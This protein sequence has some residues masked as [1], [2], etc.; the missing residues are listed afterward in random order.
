ML[1]IALFLTLGA[2]RA[3]LH[4]DLPQQSD[5]V[6]S[7]T[8]DVRLRPET[9]SVDGTMELVWRNTSNMAV[10][11]L[12]FHLYLNAF[13]DKDSTFM[14]ESGGGGRR[15][16]RWDKDHPGKVTVR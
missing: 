1:T 6:V 13:S 12:Y 14:R 2:E 3:G 11:K 8:M 7:Y 16:S 15:G 4:A 9:Q 5:R 10:D